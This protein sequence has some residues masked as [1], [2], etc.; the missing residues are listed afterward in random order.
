M[1]APIL[2]FGAA[3]D[4][5]GTDASRGPIDV[6]LSYV[7]SSLTQAWLREFRPIFDSWL[8]EY[9]GRAP[10]VTSPDLK[11]FDQPEAGSLAAVSLVIVSRAYMKSDW[12]KIQFQWLYRNLGSSRIFPIALDRNL[13]L[14]SELLEIVLSDFTDFAFVGEGFAK[15]ERYVDFQAKVRELANAVADRVER[16]HTQTVA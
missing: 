6:I 16:V 8:A 15:T 1:A 9:L 11:W 12:A 14:S 13:E 7:P 4:T 2:A 3:P 10:A 5:T